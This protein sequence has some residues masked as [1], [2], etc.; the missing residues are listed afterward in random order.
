MLISKSDYLLFLKHPAWFW[1]KKNDKDK[2][3]EY[4]ANTLR[5]FK[6]GNIFEKYVEN[7]FSKAIKIDFNRDDWDTY[8]T[9]PQRTQEVLNK[10]CKT[11]FQ[12]RF[13]ED[14]LTCI[15]DVLDRVKGNTF[16][17]YE[18]KSS[19]KVKPKH[20]HDLSFQKIVLEKTGL[21][22]RKTFVLHA[23][24]QYI[25][26]GEINPKE[27]SEKEDITDKVL[28]LK[29]KTLNNINQALQ[30]MNGD[31]PEISPR[32]SK[33]N[34]F[35]DWL[36]IFKNINPSLD[37]YSIY[38][39][40]SPGVKRIGLLEDRGVELITEIPNDIKLTKKQTLQVKA[41]KENKKIIKK[42]KIKSFLNKLKYPLYFLD[43][44]TF[45]GVIPQFDGMRPYIKMPFQYSLHIQEKPKGKIIHKE[46]LHAEFSN[47]VKNLVDQLVKDIGDKGSVIVWNKGFEKGCNKEMANFYPKH[48]DF[49]EN[50]NERLFDLMIPFSKGWY[51]DKNFFGSASLKAVLPVLVPSLSY[52]E[53]NI[54]DGLASQRTW[55]ETF[56]EGQNQENKDKIIKNLLEYCELDTFAMVKILEKL[57]KN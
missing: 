1:L 11:I 41:T 7:L 14:N 13:E 35:K 43:Y 57:K 20:K 28:S 50:I 25:R 23:N 31:I 27:L 52:N 47:P 21:S 49:L 6:E 5:I 3:P 55:L 33:L 34:S 12:G 39:L 45:G 17:L 40:A 38:N 32:H 22:I 26:K 29:E 37:K 8:N 10:N 53:L 18:I 2:I 51:V 19:T 16:D 36:K 44:E 15:V 4:D 46:Y 24:N 48:K 42:D 54:S 30:V 56:L 9:M